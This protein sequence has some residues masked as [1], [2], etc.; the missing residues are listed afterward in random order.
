MLHA[1]NIPS[2][3]R[4]HELLI[5][6]DALSQHQQHQPTTIVASS[7]HVSIPLELDSVSNNNNDELIGHLTLPAS[8][9]PHVVVADV[10]FPHGNHAPMMMAQQDRLSMTLRVSLVPPHSNRVRAS[11]SSSYPS[12]QQ[13]VPSPI[14]LSSVTWSVEL[15]ELLHVSKCL[16]YLI[17]AAIGNFGV[18]VRVARNDRAGFEHRLEQYFTAVNPRRLG[19]LAAILQVDGV[20]EVS[21]FSKLHTKYFDEVTVFHNRGSF[22]ERVLDYFT[23]Y[24]LGSERAAKGLLAN[25]AGREL[26]LLAMLTAES[27][28]E[29]SQ[30]PPDQRLDAFY[31]LYD[32][33]IT[34]D[35][36]DAMTTKLMGARGAVV[37]E[38]AF[39]ASL[40][41]KYGPE[42][43]PHTYAVKSPSGVATNEL[44]LEAFGDVLTPIVVGSQRNGASRSVSFL[45]MDATN[46]DRGPSSA[47]VS[48]RDDVHHGGTTYKSS[49]EQASLQSA[50][51]ARVMAP[52]RQDKK[53]AA[54]AILSSIREG[55]ISL[56]DNGVHPSSSRGRSVSLTTAHSVASSAVD[57]SAVRS[58]SVEVMHPLRRAPEAQSWW[59]GEIP[60]TTFDPQ[61]VDDDPERTREEDLDM[62]ARLSAP[63]RHEDVRALH[64]MMQSDPSP[65]AHFYNQ[66]PGALATRLGIEQQQSIPRA[67][68][69]DISVQTNPYGD[70][71]HSQ[72]QEF[73]L[74]DVH[75]SRYAWETFVDAAEATL[76]IP[77]HRLLYLNEARFATLCM[78]VG[79]PMELRDSVVAERQRMILSSLH[80]RYHDPGAPTVKQ[81]QEALVFMSRGG[82]S[83]VQ[84]RR[85]GMGV[86]VDHTIHRGVFQEHLDQFA[87]HREQRN[88]TGLTANNR[89]THG[90]VGVKR[91]P[92]EITKKV[93]FV[94]CSTE[95]FRV[96]STSSLG[97]QSLRGSWEN[98][99]FGVTQDAPVRF[100][101]DFWSA[102]RTE[103]RAFVAVCAAAAPPLQSGSGRTQPLVPPPLHECS[104]DIFI[105][106]VLQGNTIMESTSLKIPDSLPDVFD[107]AV[108]GA[109]HPTEEATVIFNSQHVLVEAVLFGCCVDPD[110][111][112]CTNHPGVP[113]CFRRGQARQLLSEDAKRNLTAADLLE[114]QAVPALCLQCLA[115][116]ALLKDLAVPASVDNPAS[117]SKALQGD[118]DASTPKFAQSH[119]TLPRSQDDSNYALGLLKGTESPSTANGAPTLARNQRGIPSTAASVRPREQLDRAW[120]LWSAGNTHGSLAALEQLAL[121]H[122]ATSEASEAQGLL[123][124]LVD[125]HFIHAAAHY[126]EAAR[127]NP[128]SA[129]AFYRLGNLLETRFGA[130]EEALEA[131]DKAA[132]L[133]DP[134]AQRHLVDLA[135]TALAATEPRGQHSN[136]GVLPNKSNASSQV[137]S[138]RPPVAGGSLPIPNASSLNAS[139]LVKRRF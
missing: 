23:V 135:H 9:G 6:V 106:S 117:V 22:E 95:N 19:N 4:G 2:C 31:R 41:S 102:V 64:A 15:V 89:R 75:S 82:L 48:V 65:P 109:G 69:R 57:R 125:K 49:E 18:E 43:H 114:L 60:G 136:S 26:G 66:T 36:F 91:D 104:F 50:R 35:T 27:G 21:V 56:D 103:Y 71:P 39:F 40:R 133:G 70:L 8:Y 25:W 100:Q 94:R 93:F 72:L 63:L 101:H 121:E 118:R 29:P 99:A 127:R 124:E 74:S 105:C 47:A 7:H 54:L 115:S 30:I 84:F 119:D 46:T 61:E 88:S 131:L 128:A 83:M 112:S 45:S 16:G 33:A 17:P 14:L 132:A 68:Q 58:E 53:G 129:S 78:E 123:S 42:P 126:R 13:Q 110:L 11:S 3:L 92:S 5:E 113:S 80:L 79:V 98:V 120:S 37:T 134:I 67:V 34:L 122:P 44:L 1:S 52:Q 86:E 32:S 62:I 77:F 24:S 38:R 28:P 90:G 73:L 85:V 76:Q 87:E 55:V 138:L 130:N 20:N 139:H 51:S 97:Q 59:S 137:S 10:D 107:S 81:M 116:R 12:A 96:P 111:A 108:F